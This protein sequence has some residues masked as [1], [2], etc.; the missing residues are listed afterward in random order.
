MAD[1]DEKKEEEGALK[2]PSMPG[3][4]K[5]GASSS[6]PKRGRQ[7]AGAKKSLFHPV[8]CGISSE[9]GPQWVTRPTDL[10]A[11]LGCTSFWRFL[12][13]RIAK[14]AFSNLEI[15]FLIAAFCIPFPPFEGPP[16]L[17]LIDRGGGKGG[18]CPSAQRPPSSSFLA[19]YGRGRARDH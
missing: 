12:R 14:E 8:L 9:G 16:V 11:R 18:C 7:S 3:R 5:R 15:S 10:P 19:F 4:K 1:I 6:S 13:W 2:R 17:S